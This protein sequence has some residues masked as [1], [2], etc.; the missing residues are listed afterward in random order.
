MQRKG[1]YVTGYSV[2]IL[3]LDACW[4][5]VIPGNVA[6]LE[7]YN[8]PVRLKVVTDC[9]TEQLL[10]GDSSLLNNIIQAAQELEAEGARAICGAC[11]FFGNFQD[12][13]AAAVDIPVYLSSMIQVPWIRT[14]LKP[15]KKIGI[16][17]AYAD[18]LSENL[19]KSCG[20]ND[21]SHLVIADLSQEPEFSAIIEN[22]GT[23]DNEMVRQEVV[24]A[25]VKLAE[26]NPD[27]GAIL[28]ECSD[29]PPYAADVQRAVKLPVYDFIT[30]INWVHHATSQKPY[31]GL[32]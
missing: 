4:Y 5:P 1:Q 17:T 18:G 16:L 28:L 13:V 9:L 10:E 2:G 19:F 15:E 32:F 24:D 22:R 8:F 11:G 25:A 31:Y 14:G 20:I 23:F 7:T 26:E 3:Y 29:M 12:K 27:L 30:M 6:N 21:Y